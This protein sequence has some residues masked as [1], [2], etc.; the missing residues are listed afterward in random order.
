MSLLF[1]HLIVTGRKERDTSNVSMVFKSVVVV[2]REQVEITVSNKSFKLSGCFDSSKLTLRISLRQKK[3]S[4]ISLLSPQDCFLTS[5][6]S[7]P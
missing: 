2:V 3:E 6:N 4:I 7:W 5:R 1:I